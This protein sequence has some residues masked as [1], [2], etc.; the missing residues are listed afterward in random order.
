MIQENSEP[1]VEVQ[2]SK[3]LKIGLV[4]KSCKPSFFVWK[5]I[6]KQCVYGPTQL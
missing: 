5:S 1:L 2:E 4:S 3:K 6:K